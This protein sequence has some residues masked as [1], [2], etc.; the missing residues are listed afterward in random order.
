[1][2]IN[3]RFFLIPVLLHVKTLGEFSLS[4]TA[5]FL[6]SIG[7]LAFTT[8]SAIT[9]VAAASVTLFRGKEESLNNLN[10]SLI[11]QGIYS[12][13]LSKN[14][15]NLAVSLSKETGS[16]EIVILQAESVIQAYLG[17]K[18]ISK[19][20]M[21]SIMDFAKS[22]SMDLVSAAHLLGRAVVSDSDILRRY[23]ITIDQNVSEATKLNQIIF[24]IESRFG[25]QA[26]AAT[27][28]LGSLLLL[29]N[30]FQSLM[31]VVGESLSPFV[32]LGA[33]KLTNLF[34]SMSESKI[35]LDALRIGVESVAL[36]ISSTELVFGLLTAL[37]E[38]FLKPDSKLGFLPGVKFL[39]SGLLLFFK[40]KLK[41]YEGSG[42][43]SENATKLFKKFKEDQVSLRDQFDFERQR[44]EREKINIYRN[45]LQRE[46]L[47]KREGMLRLDQIFEARTREEL[48]RL[49]AQDKLKN[50][51][52]IYNAA[53][54]MRIE[55]DQ[56]KKLNSELEK[57]NHLDYAMYQEQVNAEFKQ[58]QFKKITTQTQ[59]E[60]LERILTAYQDMGRSQ[61]AELILLSR[62]ASVALMIL[63]GE[64]TVKLT[65][66]WSMLV[67]IIG[68]FVAPIMSGL[69]TIWYAEQILNI[70][71]TTIDNP[72]KIGSGFSLDDVWRT[73]TKIPK[74]T[75]EIV[76]A[77]VSKIYYAITHPTEIPGLIADLA[78][79]FAEFLTSIF[80]GIS[81]VVGWVLGIVEDVV[82]SVID[83]FFAEGGIVRTR[84]VPNFDNLTRSIV[85]PLPGQLKSRKF[86]TEINI[87]I[88]G[89]L[90]YR[91]DRPR[92]FA[93]MIMAIEN[94][95]TT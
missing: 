5:I 69:V 72:G 32:I 36:V 83:F 54:K 23:G 78:V 67:P 10:Q 91:Y 18:E 21:L 9:G 87:K 8:I 11:T 14:Y 68:P 25:G 60:Q 29:K 61:Y 24:A 64:R 12:A 47:R 27:E 95:G 75:W 70:V 44:R 35:F 20:L 88:L 49:L 7:G 46:Q 2:A 93:E 22:K 73:I 52:F 85:T 1:M 26:K 59:F 53:L 63:L 92:K 58:Y 30:S 39:K 34:H 28:G 77:I 16:S 94:K 74:F 38:D 15:Q 81:N 4:K 66:A 40:D 82:G 31:H 86:E 51:R 55:E 71:D 45:G 57:R 17:Q 56:T 42:S 33:Q 41:K 90:S 62:A 65:W 84:S 76:K 43:F 80:G 50:D 37:F 3:R 19:E 48:R 79:G 89:G 13:D 6:S